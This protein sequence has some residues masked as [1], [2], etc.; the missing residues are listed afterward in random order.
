MSEVSAADGIE[1]GL[2]VEERTMGDYMKSLGY[3]TAY[4]GKWHL[5][6]ADRF[7]PTKR[8]FDKFYGFRGGARSYF[9]YPDEPKEALNKMER[10]FGAFEEPEGY[11]TDELGE[12]AAGFIEKNKDK[13][14]FAF[15]AFNAV[16]TP[17]DAKPEDLAQFPN[18]K[19]QSKNSCCHDAGH[20][21][22]LRKNIR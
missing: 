18:L 10:G 6:G 12:E 17:M 8:G 13:P 19:G 2:P 22:S 21:Q 15:V 7:H 14:F 4:F 16:H 5:G 1:M 11:L 20:G 9:A 3:R